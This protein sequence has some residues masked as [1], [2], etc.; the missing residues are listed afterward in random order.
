MME[1][2]CHRE[3]RELTESTEGDI[4]IWNQSEFQL[5]DFIKA[6]CE[7]TD[8]GLISS[9]KRIRHRGHGEL[10]E[11]T[12]QCIESG[13]NPAS[14]SVNSDWSSVILS[15]PKAERFENGGRSHTEQE[16]D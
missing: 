14:D 13:T 12:E 5:S 4:G 7:L 3:H 8:P 10:A 16:H 15:D 6:L 9:E 11:D 2:D 1:Q